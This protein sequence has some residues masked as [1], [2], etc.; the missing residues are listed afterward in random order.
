MNVKLQNIT[1]DEEIEFYLPENKRSDNINLIIK[2]EE[3]VFLRD[4]IIDFAK[5]ILIRY[6]ER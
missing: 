3:L 5:L 2:K 4:E 6:G 1:F